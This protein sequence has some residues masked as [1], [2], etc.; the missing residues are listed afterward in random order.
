MSK[1]KQSSVEWLIDQMK[2]YDF[3]HTNVEAYEIKIP[4]HIFQNKCNQAVAMHKQEH[5]ETWLHC[6]SQ[7]DPITFEQYYN[8]TYGGN[9]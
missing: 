7:E 1:N 6:L 3:A 2:Q 8:E 9:P 4:Y 5:L